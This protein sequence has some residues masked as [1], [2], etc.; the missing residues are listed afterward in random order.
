MFE[1]GLVDQSSSAQAV[2][3]G[4]DPAAENQLRVE[5]DDIYHFYT[6]AMSITGLRGLLADRVLSVGKE[7]LSVPA[8]SRVVID[9]LAGCVITGLLGARK[10]WIRIVYTSAA[11][12]T[13]ADAAESARTLRSVDPSLRCVLLFVYTYLFF[14]G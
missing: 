5:C 11:G 10:I 2:R 1:Q 9:N 13:A 14:R 3:L 6:E 7:K 12:S 4:L 8:D